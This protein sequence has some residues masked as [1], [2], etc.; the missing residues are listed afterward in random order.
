MAPTQTAG[1]ALRHVR[2]LITTEQATGLPDPELLGRFT[3]AQDEG[4]FAALV[5]RHG[6]LVLGVC[7]RVLGNHA[8]AEDAFQAT[9]LILSKKAAAIANHTSLPSWLYQVAYRTAVKAKSRHASRR[10]H[11]AQ[12]GRSNRADPLAEITGRELL[13]VLDE[14][15]QR[16]SER[17]RAPLVLCYL[18]G[19]TRD[20]AARELGWSLGT[21]KRRL[22]QAR[23]RLRQRLARRGLALPA[24]LLAAGLC[25]GVAAAPVPGPLADAAVRTALLASG[26]SAA[27][28]LARGTLHGMFMARI[29]ATGITLVVAGALV[30]GAVLG[31]ARLLP[32]GSPVPTPAGQAPTKEL[33]ALPQRAAQGD[34]KE[35]AVAGRV[36]DADGKPVKGARVGVLAV[37]EDWAKRHRLDSEDMVTL[38]HTQTDANGAY[39]LRVPGLTGSE[40]FPQELHPRVV[41]ARAPGHGVGCAPISADGKVPPVIR[42][43][44]EQVLRGRFIDLQGQPVK[45]ARVEV[46]FVL[47]ERTKPL[48]GLAK[49]SEPSPLWFEPAVSDEQGR[50]R[51]TGIGPQHEVGVVL[52]DDRF[53]PEMLQ[54]WKTAKQRT[55]VVTHALAPAQWVEGRVTY[56]DTGKPAAGAK[57][58]FAGTRA[59]TDKDGRY[60]LNAIRDH[61]GVLVARPPAGQP[62]LGRTSE[63]RPPKST[64]TKETIDFSLPRAVLVRGSVKEAGSG[65]PVPG[66]IVYFFPQYADNPFDTNYLAVGPVFPE[67]SGPDGRFEIPGLP[68]PGHLIVKGPTPAYIPVEMGLRQL[69]ENKPG[70]HR[71]FAHGLL[72][73][74]YKPGDEP[75]DV[76]LTL[77][78]GVTVRGTLIGP[79]GEAVA[80]AQMLTRLSTSAPMVIEEVRGVAVRGGKFELPG[81]DPERAYPVV[82]LAE[83]ERWGAIL[84]VSGKQ[85]GKPLTVRLEP[86][87][88]ANVRFLDAAGMPLEGHWAEVEMVLTPGP[89]R[90]DPKGYESGLLAADAVNLANVHRGGYQMDKARTDAQGRITLEALVPGVTYRVIANGRVVRE[91]TVRPGATVDLKAVKVM[92]E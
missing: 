39:T 30:A 35:I 22:E 54:L 38:G 37:P 77:R 10:A 9:F 57:V 19:K 31:A 61:A 44:R 55:E 69:Y 24:A 74:N 83:K 92:A 49:P 40:D 81:C 32:S 43:P 52:R 6:G 78:R 20:E 12:A 62:Y 70:G 90:Y 75:R 2:Q 34:K 21:L 25:S 84:Q 1:N 51:L 7:R 68:G 47:V 73:T 56:A 86:C 28:A 66:A 53:K 79:D 11:E 89:Y 27:A 36:L 23:L 18:E 80:A 3:A 48:L 82:F 46:L 71:R 4:A 8:D 13:A 50:F 67:L 88:A 15:L 60:R 17:L 85:S 76:E 29:R 5:R 63:L 58:S 42:L 45:G 72:R 33:A 91:F 64:V 59:V 26:P 87:G 65:K 16:L 41:M 14:E